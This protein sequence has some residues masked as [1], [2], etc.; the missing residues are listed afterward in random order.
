M[1]TNWLLQWQCNFSC[2][3]G[4]RMMKNSHETRLRNVLRNELPRQVKY[5]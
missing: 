3:I 5:I 2:K 1:V 4:F